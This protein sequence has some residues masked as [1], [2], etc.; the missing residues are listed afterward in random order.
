MIPEAV[1]LV[2][3]ESD[4]NALL[5]LAGRKG[6]NLDAEGVA[7]IAMG[8]ASPFGDELSRYAGRCT[9]AGMCDEGEVGDFR[10]GLGQAGLGRELTIEEM[11]RLGFF[12][13]VEDL[14]QELIRAVGVEPVLRVISSVGE[15]R[16]FR[17]FQ[18]QPAWRDRDLA[19][20]L[21]RFIGTKSGRKVRY[22]GLLVEALDLSRVP[23]PLERVLAHV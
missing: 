7:V 18:N 2:E 13:C 22:G 11:E 10:R 3:G 19:D 23:R 4:R 15:A 1:V 9:V 14:E 6:R 12:V 16:G 17:S 21:R 8:G 5:T 20:Q